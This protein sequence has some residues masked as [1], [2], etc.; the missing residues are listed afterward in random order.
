VP[1]LSVRFRHFLLHAALFAALLHGFSATASYLLAAVNGTKVIEVCSSFGLKKV[2]VGET[3]EPVN[4][5]DGMGKPYCDF[6]AAGFMGVAL[7]ALRPL[8][9]LTR[10]LASASQREPERV[11]RFKRMWVEQSPR[12][13]PLPA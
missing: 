9:V 2:V 6:C 10:V 7:P 5:A 8:P 3:G 1:T 11:L 4:P 12:A 13:P